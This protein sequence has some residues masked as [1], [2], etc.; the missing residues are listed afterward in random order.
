MFPL[1]DKKR[2]L[3]GLHRDN[4]ELIFFL[5]ILEQKSLFIKYDDCI[6]YN[7]ALFYN[8]FIKKIFS[9]MDL[10]VWNKLY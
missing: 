3:K 9:A 6:I 1:T 2:D 8:L 7:C 10:S 4:K 5:E